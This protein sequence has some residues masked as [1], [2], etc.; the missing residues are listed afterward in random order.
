MVRENYLAYQAIL[1]KAIDMG[2]PKHY[3]TDLGHDAALLWKQEKPVQ[4][5]WVLRDSGTNMCILDG[6]KQ[7]RDILR[8][9][10]Y[11]YSG[12]LFYKWDGEKLEEVPVCSIDIEEE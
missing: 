9:Y 4:F 11:S 12:E 5:F 2:I 6:T 7:S 8:A 1:Q 10:V 3:A